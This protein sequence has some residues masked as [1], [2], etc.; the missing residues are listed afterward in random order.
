MFEYLEKYISQNV[1]R[2]LEKKKVICW[3]NNKPESLRIIKGKYTS[4]Q[5]PGLLTKINYPANEKRDYSITVYVHYIEYMINRHIKKNK[6][7]IKTFKEYENIYNL[8]LKSEGIKTESERFFNNFIRREDFE[9]ARK[10]G[11]F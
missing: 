7:V 2:E 1:I 4:L 6:I 8:I 3:N 9:N 11:K 5:V 10:S